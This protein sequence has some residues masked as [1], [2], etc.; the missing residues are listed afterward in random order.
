MKK[1]IHFIVLIGSLLV[2]FAAC[3][4][5]NTDVSQTDEQCNNYPVIT[6]SDDYSG[7]VD[8]PLY[9][10]SDDFV[11]NFIAN[12]EDYDGTK[13]TI[14]TDFPEEWGL[15]GIERMPQGRELWMLQS[16]NREWTYLV[17]TSGSGTQRIVD[18]IP[19]GLDLANDDE[20]TLEREV[21]QWNRDEEGAF[22]VEKSYE[23]KKSI[24]GAQTMKSNDYVRSEFSRDKYII[25][26][27][28]RFECFPMNISDTLPY[29]VVVLYC[30]KGTETEDWDE[31]AEYIEAFCEEQDI[32]YAAVKQNYKQVKIQDYF[33]ND[34][35][36]LDITPEM[37]ADSVGMI[38][39]QN[40]KAP[41][42]I[43]LRGI[44]Y[45]QM[46]IQKYFKN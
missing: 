8:C 12:A 10:L 18:A 34:V 40:G 5:K 46:E 44:A 23:W 41:K 1:S 33:S 2:F 30:G 39:Y 14:H 4:E 27:M 6:I 28:G 9:A 16:L 11:R 32:Y 42:H 36:T 17:V 45:L 13:I 38:L 29:K 3:R 43:N 7:K 37:T 26:D 21:W 15:I 35:L 19:I 24:E 25:N 31:K 20:R 22:I